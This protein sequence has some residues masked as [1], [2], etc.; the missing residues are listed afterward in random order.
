MPQPTFDRWI[1]AWTSFSNRWMLW[2][3]SMFW[4]F[5]Y[6]P[7]AMD[8]Y[9]EIT[10]LA[11]QAS[12]VIEPKILAHWFQCRK[13]WWMTLLAGYWHKWLT[14]T[15]NTDLKTVNKP[16]FWWSTISKWQSPKS[17]QTGKTKRQMCN[18]QH[19]ASKNLD[20]LGQK[21]KQCICIPYTYTAKVTELKMQ[22]YYE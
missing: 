1:Q 15:Q 9:F 5:L 19:N 6:T 22:C 18:K 7:C 14:W 13:G 17:K 8:F 21:T 4:I 10:H 3:G 12:K 20:K 11:D 2:I 16:S